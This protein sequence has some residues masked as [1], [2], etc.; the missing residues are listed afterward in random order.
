M[1]LAGSLMGFVGL[2][3]NVLVAPPW[4]IACIRGAFGSF[5]LTLFL[6]FRRS[7]KQIKLIKVNWPAAILLALSNS[8]TIL[9]YFMT[10]ISSGLAFGAFILY[11]GG[12]F[13]VLFMRIFLKEKILTLH[14]FA[15]ALATGGVALIMEFW[16]G[17]FWNIGLVTGILSGIC[18]GGNTLSKKIYYKE[19]GSRAC[20]GGE[21]PETPTILAWWATL[22]MGL[23][24]LIPSAFYF[25]NAPF[26]N[27]GIALLF[28]LVPT[29][30]AFASFNFGLRADEGG[31][32]LI[33]S[34]SEPVVAT[35]VGIF[36]G[37]TPSIFLLFG[38]AA[39]ILANALILFAKR[40][41][42]LKP[43]EI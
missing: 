2:F 41:S 33:L 14:Y 36:L 11:T 42:G 1:L 23:I 35:I 39:I 6:I 5:F 38:G 19:L 12:I 40:E 37:Q 20:I 15:F 18:L 24:F 26:P 29:A 8:F 28:G 13:A 34:Y 7:I 9:L 21:Y 31:D 27:V 30:I 17:D 4:V 16:T 3:V 10:I 22:T 32:V 25:T 43:C